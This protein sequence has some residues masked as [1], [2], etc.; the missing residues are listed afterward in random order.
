MRR[1]RIQGHPR[2]RRFSRRAETLLA[3]FEHLGF[4]AGGGWHAK[5]KRADFYLDSHD[6]GCCNRF[7]AG[8][9]RVTPKLRA[10]IDAHLKSRGFRRW[11]W[12]R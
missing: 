4:L 6:A 11:S 8:P 2:D 9:K 7:P 3:Y 1:L 10:R 5:E 12:A